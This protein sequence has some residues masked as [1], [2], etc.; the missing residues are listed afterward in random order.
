VKGYV[1]LNVSCWPK[2]VWLGFDP[3]SSGG[4]PPGGGEAMAA[5]V[6]DMA[7]ERFF[8]TRLTPT[9]AAQH[10]ELTGEDFKRQ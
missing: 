10:G 5:L 9:R 8:S 3:A 2:D 4:E 1:I 6:G 7:T